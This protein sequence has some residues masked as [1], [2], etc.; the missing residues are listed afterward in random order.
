MTASSPNAMSTSSRSSHVAVS[1]VLRIFV[2]NQQRE[3]ALT[4][5]YRPAATGT[6]DLLTADLLTVDLLTVDLRLS[7]VD[8]RLTPVTALAPPHTA[9]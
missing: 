5:D 2:V 1:W 9:C 7:T 4:S 8:C 6:A 3:P